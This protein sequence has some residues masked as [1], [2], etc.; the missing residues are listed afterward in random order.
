MRVRNRTVNAAGV[1]SVA[2]V[3]VARAARD[4]DPSRRVSCVRVPQ[5]QPPESP[6]TAGAL[7]DGNAAARA[8]EDPALWE[9]TEVM[10]AVV[11]VA[12]PP[13][14]VEAA[15]V[16]EPP[17]VVEAAPLA[18]PISEPAAEF[19]PEPAAEFEPE[20]EAEPAP[21]PAPTPDPADRWGW[22]EP[23]AFEVPEDSAARPRPNATRR[24][25][26][27][28]PAPHRRR[29]RRRPL[30]ALALI[31]LAAAVSAWAMVPHSP[32]ASADPANTA[33][34]VSILP[35]P[36]AF[37]RRTIPGVYLRDYGRAAGMYGLDW[38]K[39]AAVGQI[40]SDQGRSQTPGVAQGTNRAG[41]AGPAQ[42][43]GS[44]WARY[45]VDVSGRGAS[46]PYDPADAITAMAAYLKASGAPE[47]WRSALFTYNHST[48]YVDAVLALS[49]RYLGS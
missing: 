21:E 28:R 13:V 46:N 40:E 5:A 45:G 6:A 4:A 20:P 7:A 41:A 35:H 27:R 11:V 22:A 47:D 38:T 2:L 19:E 31:V 39:L 32:S 48:A 36:S 9:P 10:Q 18:E 49:R 1:M 14:M 29:R 3:A 37:A 17:V 25:P 30:A 15:P 12:E 43:L 34:T 42:F 16:A 23:W 24:D 26:R 44:T 8:L 33:T